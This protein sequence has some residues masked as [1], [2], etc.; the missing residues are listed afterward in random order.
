MSDEFEE[1]EFLAEQVE[2]FNHERKDIVSKI[3]DEALLLAEEQ[4]KQG[5]LF[6]FTCQRGWHE[7][8]L[9]IVASK[10]VET[11]ALPT[12]ILNI[13]EN[14]NHAKGSARSIEQVSMFD[15][16]NDHQQ[17]IDKF[18]GHHMAAGMTMSID[19]IE[20]LRKELDMWMKEL[21]VTTH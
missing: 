7:G 20:H 3:T 18:G 17:L 15:I 2:H 5:H 10:I 13:D 12:L 19:N 14:Q 9:G 6:L 21:T 11:Y 1:A 8:V 4:I 16:L